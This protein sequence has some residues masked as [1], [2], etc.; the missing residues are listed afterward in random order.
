VNGSS[1]HNPKNHSPA[2]FEAV[3]ARDGFFLRA[4]L[5]IS[6]RPRKRGG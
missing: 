3:L 1:S 4:F 5:N 2:P 6:T